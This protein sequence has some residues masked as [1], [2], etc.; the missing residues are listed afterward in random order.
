M[1]IFYVIHLQT[2]DDATIRDKR[3]KRGL[4]DLYDGLQQVQYYEVCLRG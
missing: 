2:S 1:F 3:I 4:P